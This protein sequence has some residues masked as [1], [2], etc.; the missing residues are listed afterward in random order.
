MKFTFSIVA[1]AAAFIVALAAIAT[2]S[3]ARGSDIINLDCGADGTFQAVS[4]GNEGNSRFAPAH[5]I[6]THQTIIPVAFSNL[7]GSFTHDGQT[8]TFSDPDVAKAHAPKSADL[9][10]CQFTIDGTFEGGSYHVEGDVT[11]YIPGR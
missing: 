2:G 5:I 11:A 7:H 1:P 6:G 8:E 4:Y 10:D 3:A 9:M